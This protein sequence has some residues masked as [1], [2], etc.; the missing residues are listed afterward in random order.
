MTFE[1]DAEKYIKASSHQR[2]WGNKLIQQLNLKGNERILDLGCG[3]GE[4]T[5]LLAELVPNGFVLGIDASKNMIKSAQENHKAENMRFELMDINDL[6]FK[7]EFDV[8]FSNASLHWIKDHKTLLSNVRRSMR[9][10]GILLFNF[11]ADG[12][13]SNFFKVIRRAIAEKKYQM[14]FI[15]FDWP[16]Y[17]PT[18]N[19]Y[20]KIL[21]HENFNETKV[22]SENA[23][24]YFPNSGEMVK[25]IDQPSLVPFLSFVDVPD[26]Q[27]FRDFVIEQMIIETSQPD[28]TCFETFRRINAFAK[29]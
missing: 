10:E 7:D 19:E 28:G 21:N 5:A 17:M 18:V 8:V 26:K 11:A 12:N 29:K 4:L 6:N 16:W 27:T 1:F 14:Y 24:R 22:W 20:K 2:Q 3:D 15:N 9:K 13:C 23:E 25:W